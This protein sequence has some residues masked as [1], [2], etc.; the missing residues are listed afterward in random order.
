MD[1]TFQA[2]GRGF[3]CPFIEVAVHI[4]NSTDGRMT[5]AVGDHLALGDEER[6]L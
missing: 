3:V 2:F 6:H 1:L 5:E 4:E